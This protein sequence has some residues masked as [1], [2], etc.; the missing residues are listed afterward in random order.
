[1]VRTRAHTRAHTHAR[2]HTHTRALAPTTASYHGDGVVCR[3][4]GTTR[5]RR[6]SRPKVCAVVSAH[7]RARTRRRADVEGG[8]GAGRLYQVEYAMEAIS[9]AG[10]SLG[11]LAK[12]GVVLAAEKKV[13]SKLLEA[14][15][16]SEKI[17]MLNEYASVFPPPIGAAAAAPWACVCGRANAPGARPGTWRRA[18]RASRPTPTSSSIMRGR[19]RKSTSW[20]TRS[21]S[22]PSSSCAPCATSSRATPSLAVR[23][24]F[25]LVIVCL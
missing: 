20:R 4:G 25:G 12:D 22:P 6:R 9:H 18:W 16:S 10:T 21:R 1:M 11:I 13:A 23:T 3:R 24:L 14:L 17:Y 19:R 8:S 7:A 5:A 2:T 15:R